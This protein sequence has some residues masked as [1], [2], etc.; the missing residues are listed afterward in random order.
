LISLY[1]KHKKKINLK[2]KKFKFFL[3]T[4]LNRNDFQEASF[5]LM[6]Y[7]DCTTS[8]TEEFVASLCLREPSDPRHAFLLLVIL[9]LWIASPE[10][11]KGLSSCVLKTNLLY[12]YFCF[13]LVQM[14][15]VWDN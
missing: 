3:K 2:L 1:Q 12:F 10:H 4:Q 6:C 14:P 5:L 13:S 8:I 7:D 15:F 11:L 9:H